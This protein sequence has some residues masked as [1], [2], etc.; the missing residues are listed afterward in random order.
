MTDDSEARR[1]QLLR[2]QAALDGE[3]DAANALAFERDL[4]TDEVLRRARASAEAL[5][6]T[7]R[8]HAPREAAPEALRARVLALAQPR[9]A[10]RPVSRVKPQWMALA[11]SFLAVAFIAG[12][13]FGARQGASQDEAALSPLVNSFARAEISGQPFDVASSDRHTV[14]PWLASRLTLGAEVVD[15]GDVGF[16]LAGGRVDIVD[17]APVATLVYRRREHWIDVSELPLRPGAKSGAMQVSVLN[18]FQ[19]REWSDAA[20]A[21]VAVSDIDAAELD[22]FVDAFRRKVNPS[23]LSPASGD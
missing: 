2:A 21:Y 7:V 17:R 4:G 13:F 18:G 16:P 1:A 3:L 6:T 19:V 11:A 8:A 12:Y 15:L 5:R 10:R 14:K 23:A 20:R 22:T 9:P